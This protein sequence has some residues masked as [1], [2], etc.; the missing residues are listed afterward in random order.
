MSQVTA[1]AIFLLLLY[2]F[3]LLIWNLILRQNNRKLKHELAGVY[4]YMS[5]ASM[6]I[7]NMWEGRKHGR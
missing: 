4:G 3:I 5:A 1:A 2:C 6:V 7:K